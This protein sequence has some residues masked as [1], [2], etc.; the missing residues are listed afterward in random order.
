[1]DSDSRR[2]D[3]NV[4]DIRRVRIVHEG[5]Q[6]SNAVA[7]DLAAYGV[8]SEGGTFYL[9]TTTDSDGGFPVVAYDTSKFR[10]VRVWL[11][12][13]FI[14]GIIFSWVAQLIIAVLATGL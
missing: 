8:A 3:H 1:V 5:S 4:F 11:V 10:G 12:L 14:S 2:S 13:A 7:D 9:S 6:V